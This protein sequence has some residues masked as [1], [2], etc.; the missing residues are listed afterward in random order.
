M[1][2]IADGREQSL[3]EVTPNEL[4][5]V[6][7][8]L[9]A[10]LRDLCD[11]IGLHEGDEVRCQRNAGSVVVLESETGRKLVVDQDWARFIRVR[12]L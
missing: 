11:E 10:I 12:A 6:E 2:R 3:M 9:Y 4:V 1:I 7:R 5:R 8:I